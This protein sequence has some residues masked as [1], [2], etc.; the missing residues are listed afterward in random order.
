MKLLALDTS[1]DACSVALQ[2]G[3]DIAE[4]HTVRGKEHTA[5]L[6]P[7]IR[8]LLDE[9]QIRSRDL[10]AIVLGNG[11]GS[12]TGMRIA[13]SVAQGL[14]FGSGLRLVPVSS[15][16]AIAAEVMQTHPASGVVVAQDARMNEVYLG[17]Y[18]NDGSGLP[19]AVSGEALQPI[20]KLE[21]LAALPVPRCFAA[22]RAWRKYP[23]LWESNRA[24]IYR[25][26]DLHYPRARHLLGLGARAWQAG[27][28]IEPDTLAPAYIRT[29]V[30][31]PPP[32]TG[33]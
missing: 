17:I 31:A 29:K 15:M 30:A 26:L 16:A 6:I 22:G 3:D 11:P 32:G 2:I 12:F 27:E 14:A 18:R 10:D 9:A 1:S 4:Q 13:A 25:L 8:R 20:G 5:V 23:A 24:G 28:A 19:L 7:M 33:P 21:T